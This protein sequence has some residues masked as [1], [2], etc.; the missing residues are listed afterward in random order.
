M[1]SQVMQ[2]LNSSIGKIKACVFSFK[3]AK[4]IPFCEFLADARDTSLKVKI[5]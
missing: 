2:L 5:L 3:R 4:Q 1:N